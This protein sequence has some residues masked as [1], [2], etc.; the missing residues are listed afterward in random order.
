MIIAAL[1]LT[2]AVGPDASSHKSMAHKIKDRLMSRF[3]V[4]VAE[5]PN[6][7]S[8]ELIIGVSFVGS[9]EKLLHNKC[10]EIIRHL[11]DWPAAELA[12]D[13]TEI[14]HFNDLEMKRDFEKYNP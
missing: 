1:K 3:K 7:S 6:D 10:D 9:D 5:I 13:E 2:F 14:I 8:S 12:Y 11:H 4:S